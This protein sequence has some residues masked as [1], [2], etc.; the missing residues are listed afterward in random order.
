MKR[1]T[2]SIIAVFAI[3]TML[4]SCSKDDKAMDPSGNWNMDNVVLS[5]PN[6]A[7]ETIDVDGECTVKN[8]FNLKTAGVFQEGNV[9]PDTCELTNADGTWKMKTNNS[10][11]LT[12]DGD[13]QVFNIQSVSASKLILRM[14]DLGSDAPAGSYADFNFTKKQ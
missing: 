9:D 6:V 1:I 8:N 2:K 5:S 12:L 3:T 13:S 7:P 10:V 11:E 4:A 14:T